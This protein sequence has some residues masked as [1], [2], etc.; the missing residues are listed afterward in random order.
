MATIELLDHQIDFCQ[1]E[2]PYPAI[3]GGLGS[4]KTRAGQMRLIMLMLDDPGINTLYTMPTY[5]LLRLRAIPGF[6]E[7]LTELGIDYTVNKSD[8]SI[9]IP[10]LNG[11]VFFRSYDNPE[12]LVAFEV[13]HSIADELDTII[14]EKA[15]VVWRK[16]S[17]RT[18]QESAIPNSIGVVTT[19]DQGI[20]GFIYQK[21]VKMQ[22][23]GYTLIKASTRAN[24]FLPPGYIE[25]IGSN[26]D[27]IL[28]DL[29]LEG[30][31]VSLSA[32]KV[33]HFF[34]RNQ[35]HSDRELKDSDKVIHVSID[36]N[37]GGC[38]A[39]VSVYDDKYPTVIEEFVSHDTD[40]FIN[41]LV[42]RYTGRTPIIYP[43][44]SG[45]A[46]RTNAS[47]SDI[48]MIRQ[49]GYRVDVGSKNPFV[50]DRINS[51]N[52]LLSHDRI[53]VNTA[54]C[55]E[56]T[57]ALEAQGYDDKGEPEKFKHHPA[58]DDWTDSFGYFIHRKHPIRRPL[59]NIR[60]VF[61]QG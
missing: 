8:W 34:D 61:S 3:V 42:S 15:E 44:A 21:W 20:T 1:C 51:V 18:R 5:D 49:A 47:A 43:D 27:P 17:E 6:E 59:P 11:S 52:G 41:N 28:R 38:C 25:Q 39:T 2:D 36:F 12:R 55:P 29:Y 46:N 19:P 4:G 53:K 30:E 32:N 23:E 13:A 58:I 16:I 10:A 7:D 56:L 14:R 40:D 9:T 35:H 54:K 33:Y 22:Q 45:G 50:R 31:F 26:Y 60:A 37:V 57:T 48:D 24:H